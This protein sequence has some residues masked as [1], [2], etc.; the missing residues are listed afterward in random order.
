MFYVWIWLGT[1]AQRNLLARTLPKTHPHFNVFVSHIREMSGERRPGWCAVLC[2][3]RVV[4]R[5]IGHTAQNSHVPKKTIAGAHLRRVSL[6]TFFLQESFKRASSQTHSCSTVQGNWLLVTQTQ[7][8]V[9]NFLC[10][11]CRNRYFFF[12]FFI[13]LGFITSSMCFFLCTAAEFSFFVE[14]FSHWI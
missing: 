3:N 5:F 8:Y 4:H 11:H 10:F 2:A 7:R 6:F 12:I 9:L 14:L 13:C 1:S